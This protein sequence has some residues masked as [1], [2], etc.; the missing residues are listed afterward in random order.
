MGPVGAV[1]VSCT[2]AVTVVAPSATSPNFLLSL[3]GRFPPSSML[4]RLEKVICVGEVR[5]SKVPVGMTAYL[6]HTD[7]N[8]FPDPHNF[9]PDR[10][11]ANVTPQMT[12]N[13]VPFAPSEARAVIM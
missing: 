12:P 6:Q 4:P 8:V 5:S 13:F 10:W 1:E 11:L 2:G 9:V 7:P 3:L